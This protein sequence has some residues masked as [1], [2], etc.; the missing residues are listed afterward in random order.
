MPSFSN[1][2]FSLQ[3]L[4][5]ELNARAVAYLNVDISVS[6]NYSLDVAGVN[7]FRDI[8][9]NAAKLVENPDPSQ[10]EEGRKTVYDTWLARTKSENSN[11]PR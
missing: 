8:A 9:F 7:S 10:I 5:K 3:E 4:Q 6:G 11:Y 1:Q 2:S